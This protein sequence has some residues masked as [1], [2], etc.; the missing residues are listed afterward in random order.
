MSSLVI[1]LD[2]PWMHIMIGD[3]L[4]DVE[5]KDVMVWCAF[6]HVCRSSLVFIRS[7]KTA[8]CYNFLILYPLFRF[9]DRYVVTFSFID[10]F[11][12]IGSEKL[13]LL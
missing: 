11:F 13:N 10:G 4:D 6:T 1:K 9:L 5:E 2:Y 12:R 7:N 3:R 8:L